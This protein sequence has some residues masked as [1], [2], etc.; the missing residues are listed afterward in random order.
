MNDR[1][2]PDGLMLV[3]AYFLMLALGAFFGGLTILVTALPATL[4]MGS[5]FTGAAVTLAALG[6]LPL[7]MGAAMVTC[8]V[9]LWRMRRA[10]RSLAI[11]LAGLLTFIAL[12]SMP[13]L[14]MEEWGDTDLLIPLITAAV[15]LITS[16]T[17]I[18]YLRQDEIHLLFS[19]KQ[20]H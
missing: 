12:G 10:A 7:V 14:I 8:I 19:H 3:M 18:W 15:L 6:I 17:V 9:G 16:V 20:K 2:V 1:A 11:L 4:G 5:F 13:V